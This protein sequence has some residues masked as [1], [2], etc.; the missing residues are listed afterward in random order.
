MKALCLGGSPW[1]AD[2]IRR[3]RELGLD[4]LVADIDPDCP[5]R[6]IGDEFVQVDTD[7]VAALVELARARRA[8]LVLA[9]QTDRVVPVAAQI[10]AQLGL[11]G[12][13][14]ELAT[15]FTDK[16]VM[17]RALEGT[18]PMPAYQEVS[19]REEALDFADREGYPVVLKPKRRQSSIGVFV[20]DTPETLK[21][22]FENSVSQ[23]QEGRILVERFIEGPEIAVEGFSMKGRFHPLAISEKSHYDFNECLDRRVTF[24]PRYS[25][26][27][28]ARISATATA[29]VETLGLDDGIS[30]A[31]YRMRDGVPYLVEVAARGAGHG[32]A[33]RMVPHVSGVDVYELLIRRLRGEEVVVPAIK[34]RAAILNFLDFPPG[35]VRSVQGLDQARE[36]GLAQELQ[37]A[38]AAGDTIEPP[39][40]GRGRLGYAIVLGQN[41][42]EVDAKCAR[43]EELVRVTYV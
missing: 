38:F 21:S 39:I 8:D 4:T 40:D 19:R 18:V 25:D 16:R 23:S 29:V 20:V 6:A 31:E 33:T 28:L 17:R 5:G 11:P 27:T 2:V 7:D 13:R 3:A 35:E 14:P 12:L 10:N 36:E 15:R 41:R 24:P 30:H 26:A 34:H 32:V 22:R 43:I 42:D 37:L 9:E 1:Q